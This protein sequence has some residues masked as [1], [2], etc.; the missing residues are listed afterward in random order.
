M[1]HNAEQAAA[2][3]K[4]A[5][6]MLGGDFALSEAKQYLLASL[7]SLEHVQ[8]KREKREFNKKQNETYEKQQREQLASTAKWRF[9]QLDA[10]LKQ[11]QLKLQNGLN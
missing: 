11:E 1:K 8:H 7:N 10:M 4:Q 5:I 6:Q 9:A 3:V 2:L